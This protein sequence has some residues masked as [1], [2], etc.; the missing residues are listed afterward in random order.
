MTRECGDLLIVFSS[1]MFLKKKAYGHRD[2]QGDRAPDAA[3]EVGFGSIRH[4]T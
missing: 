3:S 4:S 1:V 2:G